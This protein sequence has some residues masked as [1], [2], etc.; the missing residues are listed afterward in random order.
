[1]LKIELMKSSIIHRD[2]EATRRRTKEKKKKKIQEKLRHPVTRGTKEREIEKYRGDLW[3]REKTKERSYPPRGRTMQR[4]ARPWTVASVLFAVV[5][6]YLL[7]TLSVV[8]AGPSRIS[9]N[10]P[11]YLR[12]T[13]R[14][15]EIREKG[16]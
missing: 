13:V 12:T 8:E 14:G 9:L 10:F 1:M 3:P 6:E 16:K 7:R 15:L 2:I 4:F 11:Q 5:L